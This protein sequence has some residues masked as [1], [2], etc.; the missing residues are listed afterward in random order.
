MPHK[1]IEARRAYQQRY[2][3]KSRRHRPPR[4]CPVCDKWFKPYDTDTRHRCRYCS[5]HCA[6]ASHR[7]LHLGPPEPVSENE[8]TSL[9]NEVVTENER[10]SFRNDVSTAPR[11]SIRIDVVTENE[12]TSI[13]NRGSDRAKN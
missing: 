8:R 6:A 12:R 10:T 5:E 7:T 11:T 13:P 9:R 4:Q 2:E 3:V 1:D